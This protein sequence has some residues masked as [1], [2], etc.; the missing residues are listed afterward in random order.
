MPLFRRQIISGGPVTITHPDI[1]RY[2]MT[3]TEAAQLVLQAGAIGE[4][5]DVSVL[6]MG[7]PVK[8]VDLAKRMVHLSG[9][10]VHSDQA[11]DGTIHIDFVGLRPG[12][13]L[14]EELLISDNV[15]GTGYPLILRAQEAELPWEELQVALTRLDTA[16]MQFDHEAVRGLLLQI[17]QEYA[18]QCGIADFVWNTQNRV[19][20]K[21]RA[22]K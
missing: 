10:E 7:D 5:G 2:F 3:I 15:I 8:I 16:C 1:T 14:Y 19:E 4:G 17:M 6:D 12:E 21:I 22:V 20:R 18:P 13:K 9:L 11:P